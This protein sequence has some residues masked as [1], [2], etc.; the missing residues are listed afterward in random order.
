MAVSFFVSQTSLHTLPHAGRGLSK[1][2]SSAAK[3]ACH[4]QRIA[5]PSNSNR[6]CR[7]II[8][9]YLRDLGFISEQLGAI[10]PIDLPANTED[11][12]VGGRHACIDEVHNFAFVVEVHMGP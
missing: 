11:I 7:G 10:S 4:R 1:L 8:R 6:I 12:G 2:S 5:T 9:T 3:I